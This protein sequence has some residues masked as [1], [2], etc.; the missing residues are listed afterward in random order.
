MIRWWW[1]NRPEKLRR[2]AE[3]D[4]RIRLAIENYEVGNR[5]PGD[6]VGD[7]R[8]G[9]EYRTLPP[10]GRQPTTHEQ[11]TTPPFPKRWAWILF[12]YGA[13]ILVLFCIVALIPN[14]YAH[15]KQLER[16]NDYTALIALEPDNAQWYLSRGVRQRGTEGAMA[17]FDMAIKLKPDYALAYFQRAQTRA[18]MA[19]C[20]APE[21]R[22][23]FYLQSL[24]DANEAMRLEPNMARHVA[25]RARQHLRLGDDAAAERDFTEAIRLEPTSSAYYERANFF[26]YGKKDLQSA[27]ADYT[28]AIELSRKVYALMGY[29]DTLDVMMY[30]S[31]GEVYEKL[32]EPDKAAADFEKGKQQ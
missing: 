8:Q 9:A 16:N 20:L 26:H 10:G 11:P 29:S 23:A 32:G 22:E 5:P 14:P 30:R 6:C 1:R 24:A 25:L 12:L 2:D 21:E 28:K 3:Y 4:V 27:L 7:S 31:R 15:K 18:S 19:D 17:D 13:A